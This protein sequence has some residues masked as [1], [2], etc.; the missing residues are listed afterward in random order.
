MVP[1]VAKVPFVVSQPTLRYSDLLT[2][3]V[4]ACTLLALAISAYAQPSYEV[5]VHACTLHGSTTTSIGRDGHL[6]G[7][8]LVGSGDCLSKPEH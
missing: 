5:V 2:V 3:T 4:A 7:I 8:V 6:Y 1:L